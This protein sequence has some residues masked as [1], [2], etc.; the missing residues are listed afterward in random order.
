MKLYVWN[1]PYSI[2]WGGAC[3][4]AIA[5]SEDQARELAKKSPV[6]VYGEFGHGAPNNIKE[7]GAPTRVC[8]LPYAEAFE[9][10]E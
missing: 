5:E 4:Y 2:K 8:E 3:I 7:L 1:D 9:W 10:E 6:F